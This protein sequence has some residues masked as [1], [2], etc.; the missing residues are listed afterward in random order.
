MRL[1]LAIKLS[2]ETKQAIADQ[3]IEL[4][5]DYAD[6]NWT[7]F[8]NYHITLEYFGSFPQYKPLLP[9]LEEVA[10]E[11]TPFDM[12]TLSGGVFID[13]KLTLY[14]DFYK[15]KEIEDLVRN[16]R[17][18]LAIDNKFKYIPHVTVGKARVPSKQQYFLM[19]K[20][21]ERLKFEHVFHVDE[22]VLYESVPAGK[23]HIFNELAVFK[24]GA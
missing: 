17:A 21:F 13:D 10:F 16:V 2:E 19:K 6:A 12:M 22:I 24:L 7:P 11:A 1:F 5:E 3:L 18:K 15:S 4:K 8:D 20:K 14:I 23:S 9:I